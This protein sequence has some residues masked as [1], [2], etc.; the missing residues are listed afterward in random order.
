MYDVL[1]LTKDAS[2]DDIKRAYRKLAMKNHP[3]KGGDPELFKRV[4]SAYDVLSDPAK[5]ESFDRYGADGPPQQ[6]ADVFHQSVRVRRQDCTHA[7][8]VTMAEAYNGTARHLRATVT[9]TCFACQRKCER[10]GGSG[11]T[12]IA[13]GPMTFMQA[14]NACGGAGVSAGPGCPE[15]SG[16]SK[17]HP[18]ELELKVAPGSSDG[19]HI[20]V[21]GLGEQ[22]KLQTDIPGDLIIVIQVDPHPEFARRGNEL[23]W[24]PK[25]SFMDSVN[26]VVLRCPH[27]SGEFDVDTRNFGV[28]DP[29]KEYA[30]PGK[31]A[32]GANM[33][34]IF[35][36]TYPPKTDEFELRL[37]TPARARLSET[38]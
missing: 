5:R 2:S 22:P 4:R 32:R 1:G 15:C 20:R 7:I 16:G 23:V 11:A 13:M 10:C 6:H 26:G 18:F 12:K 35:D 25:L 21:E 9:K 27:F 37:K 30:F 8:R 33:I 3:D 24:T 31:G 17:A 29:R 19:D 34:A 28:V 36:V 38:D 14:C